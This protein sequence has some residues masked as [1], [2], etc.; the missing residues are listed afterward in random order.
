MIKLLRLSRR[1]LIVGAVFAATAM[2]AGMSPTAAAKSKLTVLFPTPHTTYGIPFYIA[3]DKGWF[4]DMDLEIE[5]INLTGSANALRTLVGGHADISTIG[6]STTMLS[7]LAGSGVKAIGSWQPRQD[8][9]VIAAGKNTKLE[10]LVGKMFAGAGGPGMLNHMASMILKKYG[11]N[12]KVTHVSVGGHSDRVAAVIAGK[13][14]YTMV[15]TLT[16]TRASDHIN[17]ITPVTK[18]L[19]KLGYNY[20]VIKGKD[21]DDPVKREALS[22]FMKASIMGA[23]YA[24]EHPDEA[25]EAMHKRTPAIPLDLINKVVRELNALGVWGVNGG[26]PSEI[27]DFT[28][29]TYLQYGVIKKAVFRDQVLDTSIIA[30]IIKEMGAY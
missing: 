1:A 5:A 7:I 21:L 17:L 27:T 18:E 6:P 22:K 10:D 4:K 29:A 28:A 30:P 12:S 14:D 25:A 20:L 24:M 26:I 16:A 11:L 23:R 8:Y 2:L 13:V 9:Q 3:E 19:G 15:N